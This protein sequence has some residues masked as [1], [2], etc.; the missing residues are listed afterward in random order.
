MYDVATA[1]GGPDQTRPAA[2]YPHADDPGGTVSCAHGD[3]SEAGYGA[4]GQA[5]YTIATADGCQDE[6]SVSSTPPPPTSH[7]PPPAYSPTRLL[8]YCQCAHL[9]VRGCGRC[10]GPCHLGGT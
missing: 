5:N 9:P 10:C 3:A 2:P 8:A 7:L 1:D 6:G 4:G